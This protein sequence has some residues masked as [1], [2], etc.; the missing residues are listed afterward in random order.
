[1]EEPNPKRKSGLPYLRMFLVPDGLNVTATVHSDSKYDHTSRPI[2]VNHVVSLDMRL[3]SVVD[4]HLDTLE[5]M[6]AITFM[7]TRA[8]V[9][10]Y[11]SPRDFKNAAEAEAVRDYIYES[12]LANRYNY[13]TALAEGLERHWKSLLEE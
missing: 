12:I 5:V 6:P 1:M 11:F 2:V 3:V 8:D 10:W 9:S 4:K 13:R 7:A